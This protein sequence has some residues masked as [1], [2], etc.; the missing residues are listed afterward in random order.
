MLRPESESNY[1]AALPTRP[2]RILAAVVGRGHVVEGHREGDADHL[3]RG[4]LRRAERQAGLTRRHRRGRSFGYAPVHALASEDEV[5]RATESLLYTD[6]IIY[7][8]R[9]PFFRVRNRELIEDP[10]SSSVITAP[11]P[12]AG[13][14]YGS[15]R[16][17]ARASTRRCVVALA[18][19]SRSQRTR[20]TE[21]RSWVRGAAAS[22]R[23]IRRVSPTH[24]GCGSRAASAACSSTWCS[25]SSTERTSVRSSGHSKRALPGD[26]RRRLSP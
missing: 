21:L 13:K 26:D 16:R 6:H 12:N 2:A 5:N 4:P 9:V 15:T 18:T 7:S 25:R 24:S 19:S 22:S 8:P 1:T 3:Q 11:A 14:R 17:Q 23:T 10:F 20:G